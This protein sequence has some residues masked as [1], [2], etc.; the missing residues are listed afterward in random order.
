MSKLIILSLT[1]EWKQIPTKG[2]VKAFQHKCGGIVR[3]MLYTLEMREGR[4]AIRKKRCPGC[5]ESFDPNVRSEEAIQR[6]K[7]KE[8]EEWIS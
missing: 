3:L 8:E 5:R 6:D 1:N 2:R 7:L 4:D